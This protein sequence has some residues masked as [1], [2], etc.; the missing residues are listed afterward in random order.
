MTGPLSCASAATV[1]APP[2]SRGTAHRGHSNINP[3]TGLATDYLNHFNEAIMLLEMATSSPEIIA[4]FLA[5]QPLSYNEHFAASQFGDRDVA[6]AAYENADPRTRR[7]FDGLT[8][9]MTMILMTAHAV[10][11]ISPPQP[12]VAAVARVALA[13]LKPMVARAGAII[14]GSVDAEGE[15]ISPQDAVDALMERTCRG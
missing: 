3:I 8:G 5:W 14:N 1:Q 11:L 7:R 10:L 9:T 15:P 12:T 2:L 13:N 4:D 6:I